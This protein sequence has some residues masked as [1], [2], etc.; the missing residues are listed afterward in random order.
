LENLSAFIYIKMDKQ[1]FEELRTKNNEI[2]E[3]QK[4]DRYYWARKEEKELLRIFEL[5]EKYCNVKYVGDSVIIDTNAFKFFKCGIK[6][7][8]K[9][10]LTQINELMISTFLPLKPTEMVYT[11]RAITDFVKIL[12][13]LWRES[14]KLVI[15]KDLSFHTNNP[16][17]EQ[18]SFELKAWIKT[19]ETDIQGKL[20][21]RLEKPMFWR[22]DV[23]TLESMKFAVEINP[24]LKIK[25][26]QLARMEKEEYYKVII[27]PHEEGIKVLVYQYIESRYKERLEKK[28]EIKYYLRYDP[29]YPER[30]EITRLK[31]IERRPDLDTDKRSC[32]V[33]KYFTFPTIRQFFKNEGFN[34][35][36][37]PSL[38]HKLPKLPFEIKPRFQLIDYPQA[39]AFANWKKNSCIGT[40]EMPTGTGKSHVGLW[41]IANL[42]TT[43]L[44]V[45]PTI[46]IKNQWIK[47]LKKWLGIPGKYIGE[48]Y[49]PV[50]EIK[51]ITVALIQSASKY[52]KKRKNLELNNGNNLSKADKKV[53]QLAKEVGEITKNFG[54]FITDE[55]HHMAAPVWQQIS[56]DLKTI[57]RMSLTATPRRE[58]K[59]EALIFFMMGDIVFDTTYYKCAI[60]SK[61]KLVSP[62][63]YERITVELTPKEYKML[64]LLAQFRAKRKWFKQAPYYAKKQIKKEIMMIEEELY[65]LWIMHPYIKAGGSKNL[66]IMRVVHCYAENKFRELIK[67][68]KKHKDDRILI[69]NEYVKGTKIISDYLKEN[70]IDHYV[71]TGSTPEE[72]R[73]TMLMLFKALPGQIILTT[74]V[75]D[76]GVDVPNCNVVIIFNGTKTPRQM[77]QRIGRGCRYKPT[78]IE[79]AYELIVQSY[80][81]DKEKG[82][83][84]TQDYEYKDALDKLLNYEFNASMYRDPSAI[85]EPE[86]QE[87]L[88]NKT[89]EI[90]DQKCAI[91]GC[92]QL[93]STNKFGI[94]RVHIEMMKNIIDKKKKHIYLNI[95]EQFVYASVKNILK[96]LKRK[97]EVKT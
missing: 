45:V 85:V 26:D 30:S 94:C 78:K 70:N 8:V 76:E 47:F 46:N 81:I 10:V 54:L 55:G 82:W 1:Q 42:Q 93:K 23:K 61:P 18:K 63:K 87:E 15:L 4:K 71:M 40:I 77:I 57:N 97:K 7:K 72:D 38:I 89:L 56:V 16:T 3:K 65:D 9:D 6:P 66:S 49:G 44:I 83:Y 62:I 91:D 95:E 37:H 41:A 13:S 5:I 12:A 58:D 80:K 88:V 92:F 69:F 29:E 53:L 33:A 73:E 67:I 86:K 60:K 19:H 28:C 48:F 96:R 24:E 51:P 79:Y 21:Y 17:L 20:I 50:K 25:L 75:L 2:I 36:V 35:L 11:H 43:T 14:R 74:T 90:A 52:T 84:R 34:V 39:E 68:L 22:A 32:Y 31:F 59:N 27:N 64:D